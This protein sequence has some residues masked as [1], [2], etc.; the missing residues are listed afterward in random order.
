MPNYYKNRGGLKP[1]WWCGKAL[2]KKKKGGYYFSE[3]LVGETLVKV[4][5]ICREPTEKAQ[6]PGQSMKEEE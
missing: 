1:C 3:V 2:E 5:K 4:H 6:R